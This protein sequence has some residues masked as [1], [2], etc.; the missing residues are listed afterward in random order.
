MRVPR[1]RASPRHGGSI[2]LIFS[3][4]TLPISDYNKVHQS[5]VACVGMQPFMDWSISEGCA[6]RFYL[7]FWDYRDPFSL[8]KREF[9]FFAV[10]HGDFGNGKVL[11]GKPC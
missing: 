9:C 2:V 4:R 1:F 7:I 5:E 10:L 3:S 8:R 11:D 6:E